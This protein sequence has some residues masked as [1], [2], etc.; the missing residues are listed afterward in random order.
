MARGSIPLRSTTAL[1]GIAARSSARTLARLPPCLP[2]GVRSA[3]QM[4]ASLT[5]TPTRNA[6]RGTRNRRAGFSTVGCSVPHSAFRLPRSQRHPYRL[7]LRIVVQRLFAEVSAE[8]RELI[9][10][11]RCGGIVEVVRVHPHGA[12]LDRARHAVRLLH[13]LGPDAR[14]ETVARAVGELMPC[15]SFSNVSTANTGPKISSS[16]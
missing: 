10:A 14:R 5:G 9:A 11:E 12:R 3:E 16:T 4:Y 15:A 6:E 13:V 8:P 7:E 1:I 2:T